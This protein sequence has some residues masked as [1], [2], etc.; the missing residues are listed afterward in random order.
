VVDVFFTYDRHN[1]VFPEDFATLLAEDL[2]LYA[3]GKF[4]TG[5]LTRLRGV[6]PDRR[7]GAL[8]CR[9]TCA[10]EWES[11]PSFPHGAH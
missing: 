1:Y 7:E 8:R 5:E 6:A 4:D 2:R 11:I 9:G 3:A 10:T